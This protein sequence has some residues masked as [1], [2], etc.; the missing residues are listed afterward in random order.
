MCNKCESAAS[1]KAELERNLIDTNYGYRDKDFKCHELPTHRSQ[2]CQSI[3]IKYFQNKLETRR[4]K[5]RTNSLSQNMSSSKFFPSFSMFLFVISLSVLLVPNM[6]KCTVLEEFG[7]TLQRSLGNVEIEDISSEYSNIRNE[8]DTQPR[9]GRQFQDDAFVAPQLN[10]FNLQA[11]PQPRTQ[12]AQF[13]DLS[14][15]LGGGFSSFGNQAQ[16]VS[17]I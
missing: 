1:R 10:T 6:V 9:E 15:G 3:V 14:G 17:F 7:Q 5:S 12:G 16:S 8:R 2:I 4:G 13:R 11:Q